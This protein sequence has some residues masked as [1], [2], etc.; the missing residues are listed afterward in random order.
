MRRT[1]RRWDVPHS[2]ESHRTRGG[3]AGAVS[4]DT[5]PTACCS[6]GHGSKPTGPQQSVSYSAAPLSEERESAACLR[7]PPSSGGGSPQRFRGGSHQPCPDPGSPGRA[8]VLRTRPLNW[9]PMERSANSGRW[10]LP[11]VMCRLLSE[12]DPVELEPCGQPAAG[13]PLWPHRRLVTERNPNRPLQGI[14]TPLF[15]QGLIS[16]PRRLE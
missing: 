7:R 10:S 15:A 2:R 16:S 9:A 1:Q 4:F 12:D 13:G 8:S 14:R 5:I 6:L 3:A 11:C